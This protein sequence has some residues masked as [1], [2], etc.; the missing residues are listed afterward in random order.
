MRKWRSDLAFVDAFEQCAEHP[1][2]PVLSIAICLKEGECGTRGLRAQHYRQW[3]MGLGSLVD[4]QRSDRQLLA[5]SV[6]KLNHPKRPF[7]TCHKRQQSLFLN[8]LQ[9]KLF[10]GFIEYSLCSR[11]PAQSGDK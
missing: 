10:V 11:R 3:A 7:A 9:H 5:D 8:T 2:S 1:R 6:E 4:V